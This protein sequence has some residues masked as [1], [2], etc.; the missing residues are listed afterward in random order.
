MSTNKFEDHLWREFVREHGDDLAQLDRPATGHALPRP[1]LVAAA[2]LGL[3]GGVTAMVLVLGATS[4]PAFAVTR[5]QN[6]T[7][8]VT[9]KSSNGIAGANAKLHQLGIRA[10]VMAKVPSGAGCEV[11]LAAA[12]AAAQG[13]TPSTGSTTATAEW[14][15]NPSAI[16]KNQSL[17][18]TPAAAGGNS[19]TTGNS[20]SGG[21][22]QTW[23][24]AALTQGA[25]A[26]TTG[27][28]GASGT[29]GN[30]AG[31]ALHVDPAGNN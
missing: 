11:A 16:A 19:G 24:C 26:G 29:T 20:G 3:A 30:G 17:V 25:G 5:N 22:G 28:S 2:G 9:I 23:T 18:L 1:R 13:V 14:T 6:G 27:P 8:T 21:A 31:P 15:I 7:V 4:A 10:Q 12:Q